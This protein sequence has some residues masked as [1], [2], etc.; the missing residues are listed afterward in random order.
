MKSLVF[1]TALDAPAAE[2]EE[3]KKTGRCITEKKKKTVGRKD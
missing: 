1:P 3:N 2:V